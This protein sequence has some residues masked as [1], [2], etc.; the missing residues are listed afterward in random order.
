MKFAYTNMKHESH[1]QNAIIASFFF[2]PEGEDFERSILGMYRSL[3]LQ[4]LDEHPDPRAVLDGSSVVSPSQKGPLSL[5]IIKQIF[6]NAVSGLGHRS[7][8]CFVDALDECDEQEVLDVV[9]F[10]EDVAKKSIANGVSFRICFSCRH[11]RLI[12]NQQ[13]PQL[14]LE[15]QP[16]HVKDLETYVARRLLVDDSLIELPSKLVAK[17]VGNF[18]WAIS[19]VNELNN[20]YRRGECA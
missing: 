9:C 3:L 8:T 6:L 1:H 19:V 18:K 13:G 10:F 5:N 11:Y 15:D 2:N 16:G 12:T 14:A 7:L 4:L 17:A 20:D